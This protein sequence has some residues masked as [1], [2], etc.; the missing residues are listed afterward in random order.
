MRKIPPLLIHITVIHNDMVESFEYKGV[1]WLPDKE[2]NQI[3]GILKFSPE[4]GLI[5]DLIGAFPT[6][7]NNEEIILGFTENGKCI[8]LLNT[9]QTKRSFSMPGMELETII[10]NYAFIGSNHLPKKSDFK[11][12]KA[13]FSLKHLDEWTNKSEGFN[14]DHNW[15]EKEIVIK[16]KLPDAIALNINDNIKLTLNPIAKG[17]SWNI[18][19]KEAKI[20]QRINAIIE[21]NRKKSFD[22]LFEYV[23]YFQNLLTLL[24]QRKTYPTEF[25]LLKKD[26]NGKFSDKYELVYQIKPDKKRE[27]DLIP[28]D[29]LISYPYIREKFPTILTKWFD[30]QEDLHTCF[31]PYF[32]NFYSST[33]YTSDRFLNIARAIEA[34]HR[35][36][37]GEIDPS[38][39]RPYHY[40]KRVI[41]IFEQSNRAFNGLLKIRDKNKFASKIKDFRNDFTHSNPVLTNRDKKYLETHY[42]TE[43]ATIILTSSILKYLGLSIKEIRTALY[44]TSLYTHIKYK[45]K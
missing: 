4:N 21:S 18:V 3:S 32:N 30:I 8:T 2:N 34:F 45:L 42:L 12:Y 41:E 22:T 28:Q 40:K 1:W 38:T 16:Y 6:N 19:Q 24:L 36:T 35:D 39:S 9:F 20:T 7:R 11:F 23:L 17:P 26:N 15:K 27:K 10:C 37:I 43:K 5:L 31:I 25:Y 29:M 33:Q 13:V 14:I 44:N